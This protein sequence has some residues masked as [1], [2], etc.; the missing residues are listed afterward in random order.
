MRIGKFFSTIRGRIIV[1]YTCLFAA[2]FVFINLIVSSMIGG[3]MVNQRCTSQS[4]Q[5]ETLSTRLA[6]YVN[7]MDVQSVYNIAVSEGQ[8]FNGRVVVMDENGVV[9]ADS[10]SQLNGRVLRHE[11]VD[12]VRTGEA[13]SAWGFHRVDAQAPSGFLSMIDKEWAV[14]YTAS[15]VYQSHTV[16][17]VLVSVSIQDIEDTIGRTMLQFFGISMLILG[18]LIVASILISRWI[19]KPLADMTNVIQEMSRGNFDVRAKETGI[20]EMAEMGRTFNMMSEKLESVDRMRSE[21]VAN[22][23][24]ELKTPLSA[25]KILTESLLYQ[26]DVPED[27]YKEFLS[28]INQQIDRLVT[29]LNDLLV[30]SQIEQNEYLLNYSTVNAKDLVTEAVAQLRPLALSKGIEMI[31]ETEDFMLECDKLKLSTA[32]SNL[33]NNGI[34]Y[35][36]NGGS[37]KIEAKQKGDMAHFAVVDT[38]IGIP[39]EDLAHI[40]DRFYRVDK[41]RSRETGGTGLGLSIVSRIC[42]LHGGTVSVQSREGIGSVFSIDVPLRRNKEDA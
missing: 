2:A 40:F 36:A 7:S 3:F 4:E 9:F 8:N 6:P 27:T 19:S 32:I 33:L 37:V 21:F 18:L 20:P 12:K 13:N 1:L 11:E 15:I 29:L 28:D 14:Y 34:K 42:R 23:S 31:A 35:T 5:V 26:S 41:A 39:K 25:I 24:H 17:I 30:L 38:G 10:H 16:G 22:A